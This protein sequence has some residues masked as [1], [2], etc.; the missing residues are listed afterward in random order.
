M[1]LA[2]RSRTISSG[3]IAYAFSAT[4]VSFLSHMLRVIMATFTRLSLLA[5][6]AELL[7]LSQPHCRPLLP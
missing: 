2:A 7:L 5:T 6:N 3:G 4:M 1:L